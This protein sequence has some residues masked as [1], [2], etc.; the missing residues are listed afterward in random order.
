MRRVRIL[1]I[2]YHPNHLLVGR[3][4]WLRKPVR[5]RE[6]EYIWEFYPDGEDKTYL[7]C[8]EREFEYLS[9]REH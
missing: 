7:L 1:R 4:G 5:I 3:E 6:G 8:D 2:M 9:D